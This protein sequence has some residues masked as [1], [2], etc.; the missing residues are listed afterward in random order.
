MNTSSHPMQLRCQRSRTFRAA[1]RGQRGVVLIMALIMLV[2]ISM[3]TAMSVR[4]ATSSE[5]VNSNVRQG[6]LATQAAET[7][8]RYCEQGLI[9]RLTF[10]TGVQTPTYV[11]VPP[12]ASTVTMSDI[13]WQEPLPSATP[14]SMITG[15]WDVNSPALANSILVVPMSSVNRAGVTTT[16]SRPPECMIERLNP[17]TSNKHTKNFVIT[18]RGF[19]PEVAAA[20]AARSR[21]IGSEVWMQ[22]TLEFN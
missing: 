11:I 9:T 17:V 21:P 3:L 8:L 20:D 4:N 12:S 15:N 10:T 2:V 13:H 7:A 1:Y 14:T 18:A 19:G 16:F 6:Q 22:T 5:G